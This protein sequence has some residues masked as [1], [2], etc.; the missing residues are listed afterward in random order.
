MESRGRL[1]FQNKSCGSQFALFSGA[2]FV[3]GLA[4]LPEEE[5]P[6]VGGV[7]LKRQGK[8]RFAVRE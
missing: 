5:G 2:G 3:E 8:R 1:C 6:V 7:A 4:G